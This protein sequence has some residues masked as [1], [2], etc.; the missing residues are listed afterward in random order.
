MHLVLETDASFW[1]PPD[2]YDFWDNGR[3]LT[4]F[5]SALDN[6]L[7]QLRNN[8]IPDIFFPEVCVKYNIMGP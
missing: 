4:C 3:V 1:G 2:Y 7:T 5:I 8:S 6:L